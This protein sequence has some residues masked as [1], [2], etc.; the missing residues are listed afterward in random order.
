M[1]Y[2]TKIEA[3]FSNGLS[4]LDRLVFEQELAENAKLQKEVAA[5]ELAQSL[6]GFTAETLPE[7]EIVASTA[8]KT[9]DELIGFVANN[10]SEE[11]IL[12]IDATVQSTAITRTLKPKRNRT[13]W[14]AAASIAIILSFIGLQIQ[15][16]STIAPAATIAAAK[17]QAPSI[18][19]MAV[20]NN[21]LGKKVAEEVVAAFK[22]IQPSQKTDNTSVKNYEPAIVKTIKKQRKNS[23]HLA[24][25]IATVPSTDPLALNTVATEVTTRKVVDKGESLSYQAVENIILKEGFHA[26]AGATFTATTYEKTKDVLAS[27][28]ALS[29]Q[30]KVVYQAKQTITLGTGFQVAADTEFTAKTTPNPY[31]TTV[32]TNTIISEEEEIVLKAKKSISLESGFEVKAGANF[33][34][35]IG[36]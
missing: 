12:G 23:N 8:T 28:A 26:K 17:K 7:E 33:T 1:N 5:F 18:E 15:Q 9:A 24:A 3:Y 10:L 16:G 2:F 21:Q 30:Q 19:K 32:A 27:T 13:A 14:L 29:G 4:E 35:A 11:Q 25:T 6:F 31:Q 20:P 36:K 22:N 34:A